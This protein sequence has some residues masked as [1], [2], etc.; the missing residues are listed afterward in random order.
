[1]IRVGDLRTYESLPP[2]RKLLTLVFAMVGKDRASELRL[3]YRPDPPAVRM[4]YCVAGVPY[5]MVPPPGHL[6]PELF[7]VFWRETH[8]DPADRPRWWQRLGRRPRF[9]ENPAAGTLT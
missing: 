9:P 8:F 7:R 5:E 1:M 6:W 4:W 2:V 3:D